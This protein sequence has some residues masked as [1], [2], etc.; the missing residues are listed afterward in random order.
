MVAEGSVKSVKHRLKRVVSLANLTYEEMI[1]VLIHIE[2]ILNSRP[3]TP[4]SS[5]PSDL[6]ALTP[7]NFLIGRTFTSLP[8][9]EVK[10]T[11][12]L[13]TL[14]RYMR[15]QKLKAH[16]WN[17]FYMEYITE[18]QKRQKW[19]KQGGQLKLGGK[20]LRIFRYRAHVKIS[21]GRISIL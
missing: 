12:A 5:D 17:R 11:A 19:Q 10:E 15:M 8:N 3:L 4:M 20:Y 21:T 6:I 13:H 2:A 1:T 7:S 18:P 9:P 14:S 16:F